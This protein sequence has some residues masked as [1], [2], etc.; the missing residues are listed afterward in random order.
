MSI[1]PTQ[2]GLV[3]GWYYKKINF[4]QTH[5]NPV[6]VHDVHRHDGDQILLPPDPK[7]TRLKPCIII[8][9]CGS[10]TFA[11]MTISVSQSATVERTSFCTINEAER[12]DRAQMQDSGGTP[13]APGI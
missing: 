5:L 12:P 9:S 13:A 6:F 11:L 10:I 7:K 3:A 8:V 4:F 2:Y 1:Q